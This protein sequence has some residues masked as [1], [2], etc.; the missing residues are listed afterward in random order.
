MQLSGEIIEE[1]IE[2]LYENFFEFR[3]VSKNKNRLCSMTCGIDMKKLYSGNTIKISKIQ[4]NLWINSVAQSRSKRSH[5]KKNSDQGATDPTSKRNLNSGR[6]IPPQRE[7]WSQ[8]HGSHPEENYEWE[9][10]DEVVRERDQGSE[11]TLTWGQ[12]KVVT[13]K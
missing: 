10:T 7:L 6:R 3:S 5:P 9:M 2:K 1:G 12:P 11:L 4:R 8:D 13:S